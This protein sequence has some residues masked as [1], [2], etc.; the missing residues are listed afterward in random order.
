MR[1]IFKL[2]IVVAIF[3][4]VAGGVLAA[5]RDATSEQIESQVLKY[6]TG[7][8]LEKLFEGSENNPLEDRFKIQDGENEIDVFVGTLDGKR[9]VVAF[10]SFGMGG[11][12]GKVNVLV[13]FNL[14]TDDLVG[15]RVTTHTETQGIG[16][17]STTDAPFINQFKGLPI[18]TSFK[19]KPDGGDIDA[20]S[21]A[22]LTS[23]AVSAGIANAV[24]KY[25]GLKSEILKKM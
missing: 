7:P 22:T 3:A 4:G 18:D 5:V 17:R 19:V 14:D 10:E 1:E 8:S 24:E 25:K 9:N 11:Y 21:G 23:R 13:G 16:S 2:F 12:D 6:V 15:M 20:L